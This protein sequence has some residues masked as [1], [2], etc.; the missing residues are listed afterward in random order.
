[1]CQV[2]GRFDM[3]GE[4]EERKVMNIYYWK[5]TARDTPGRVWIITNI[6]RR[7]GIVKT[8]SK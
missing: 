8:E 7:M 4:H 5:F 2:L 1:M 3:R 6:R